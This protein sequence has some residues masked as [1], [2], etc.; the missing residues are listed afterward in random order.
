[1]ELTNVSRFSHVVSLIVAVATAA[2]FSA[3]TARAAPQE[4]PPAATAESMKT[5]VETIP[6]TDV[7]FEMVAI[8]GGTFDLGS[9]ATEEKRGTD[10][11]PQH[12]V[13][14]GPFWMGSKEVT[15]D[16]FEH[17]AFSLDIKKK[18]RDAV[19]PAKQSEWEKKADAVTRPTAP[20]ADETFGFGR[21][22][23]PVICVTHH[24][25]MEYTRWLSAKTGKI[26][27]LP[28]EAEWEYACRAGSKTA[29]FWGDGPEK[30][31]EYSWYVNNAEKPN[32]VGKKKPSPWGL[33]DIHGNVAEWCLDHY[34][35]DAYKAYPTDKPTVG[36]V[37]LPDAKEYPYVARGG[38]WDDDAHLLRSAA[39]RASNLEWSVQDPQRPQSI[40]WHTDA[41]FVGFRIVRPL[42]EQENLKG[43]KSQ[44]VKG[45]TT[46]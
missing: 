43:L 11:A 24:A 8:P 29:Y 28:T 10:E 40:W 32:L 36:P 33:Y 46:R 41:T 6:G 14:V 45:K 7:K 18:K 4:A 12:P 17:F 39:R 1:L 25:A 9:P 23:Q 21:S 37:N 27:R 16:E 26:Y 22:G 31:D 5:Y 42:S 20:Y 13:Q 44:V 30:I 35:A 34:V 2:L 38:S 19:D 3:D 15:W